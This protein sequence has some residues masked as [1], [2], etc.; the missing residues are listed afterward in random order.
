MGYYN[1]PNLYKSDGQKILL[2]KECYVL[3][4]IHGTSTAIT[5]KNR[6]IRFKSGGLDHSTFVKLFDEDDLRERFKKMGHSSVRICGEGYGGECQG[7][8]EVYG[9]N[10]SFVAF[11]VKVGDC[12]LNVPNASDVAHKMGLD[13]VDYERV[14][15]EIEDLREQ[16]NRPSV[17]AKKNGMGEHPREG[18]VIRPLITLRRN[19]D[20]RVI[21]KWKTKEHQERTNQPDPK[22]IDPEE[23]KVMRDAER[24]ADEWVNGMRL[25]HVLDDFRAQKNEDPDLEDTGE[26]IR[27]MIDDVKKESSGE[28]EGD[29]NMIGK[30][31][32]RKTA[33]LFHKRL[34]E[35][36]VNENG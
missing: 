14:P 21:A 3:E 23:M 30:Q 32:G 12:W 4:K 24:I 9:P 36:F 13:F 1:I 8:G 18:I 10:Y 19:N 5:W 20:K 6:N 28:I 34:E 27:M 31:I 15:A 2:F 29:W 7:M 22:D 16:L 25:T 35:N 33:D 11:D 26:V 17:Q